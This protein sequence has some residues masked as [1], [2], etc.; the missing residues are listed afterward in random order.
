IECPAH[1]CNVSEFC[2]ITNPSASPPNGVCADRWT[3]QRRSEALIARTAASLTANM[4][5]FVDADNVPTRVAIRDFEFIAKC[6]DGTNQNRPCASDTDCPVGSCRN[7]SGREVDVNPSLVDKDNINVYAY[8]LE[9]QPYITEVATFSETGAQINARAIELFNPSPLGIPASDPPTNEEYFIYEVDPSGALASAHIA[10]LTGVLPGTASASPGPFT[11]YYSAQDPGAATSIL[12]APRKGTP[13][14]L[15]GANTLAFAN[16]WTIYLVR[17]VVVAPGPPAVYVD[18]AIDQ[19]NVVGDNIAKSGVTPTPACGPGNPPCLFSLGRLVTNSAPWPAPVPWTGD[20]KRDAVTLGDW[21]AETNNA[22]H[23]VEIQFANTG[24]FGPH[25]LSTTTT[26]AFPTTGSLSL[27]I[28]YAN[29]AMTDYAPPAIGVTPGKVTNLAFTSALLVD[30]KAGT[31]AVDLA[32]T[33][34]DTATMLVPAI[35]GGPPTVKDQVAVARQNQIDNGRM[36]LFDIGVAGNNPA[37]GKLG[38][39]HLPPQMLKAWDPT[40]TANPLPGDLNT[41]PWGQLVFDYFTALP[42]SNPGPYLVNPNLIGLP[43][44]QPRVDREGARVYGR[45]NLNAAPWTVLS[46]LPFVPMNRIPD[47]F[48]DRVAGALWIGAAQYGDAVSIGPE[49]AQAIVAYREARPLPGPG[50]GNLT[51]NYDDGSPATGVTATPATTYPRGW[52]NASPVSRRGTGFMS[53]GELANV[54]HPG[55]APASP[56]NTWPYRLDF[57]VIGSKTN[58]NEEN[59]IDA[60][61]VLIALGDWTAVRSQVFTVYGVIRG[62]PA[63]AASNPVQDADSR[64]IRFQET[65]DRLPT[66]FG[67]PLPRRIGE[68]TVAKLTDV[69]ND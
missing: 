23:P 4:I 33:V 7:L 47:A 44:S 20:E 37:S 68:P 67:E 48:R 66:F 61:A 31:S 40:K 39:H 16:G 30:P 64:A 27:L 56:P 29:R 52:A 59:F 17:R 49:L 32:T 38:A 2:L 19:F 53:V 22:I 18:I 58:K 8:G 1:P 9:R 13:V 42:L 51:G 54:R 57:G 41:L 28:R 35:A 24:T 11:T 62:E 3:R 5:D 12:G 21:N 69:N 65:I 43:E 25:I 45:I 50:P 63:A 46:G 55:A 10:T 26:A 14:E 60:A 6:K 36:P 15:N 34:E